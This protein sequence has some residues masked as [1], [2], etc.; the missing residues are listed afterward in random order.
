MDTIIP[1]KRCSKCREL[2]PLNDFYKNR[3]RVDGIAPECKTCALTY[4]K[5][6]GKTRKS[7]TTKG[8]RAVGMSRKDYD[9][10]AKQQNGVCAICKKPETGK[11]QWGIKRLAVDH[12]HITGKF[13]GLLCQSCNIKLG[14]L[15][16][17]EFVQSA[18]TYLAKKDTKLPWEWSE[19]GRL[20]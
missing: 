9:D 6:W 11:N 10:I 16:D 18:L 3:S 12:D 8:M 13:R 4:K 2:K 20:F 5:E 1:Q 15:D 17:H 19:G 14:V 7:S